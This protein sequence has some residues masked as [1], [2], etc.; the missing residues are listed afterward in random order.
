MKRAS[1]LV[2][3]LALILLVAPARAQKPDYL[4]REEVEK[5]RETQEPNLRIQLFLQFA[6]ERLR[7]F[8]KALSKSKDPDELGQLLD[9][10]IRALDDTADAVERPLERGGVDLHKTRKPVTEG[11][12]DYLARLQHVQRSFEV[13]KQDL[14]Y[15]L[16][17]AIEAT[18][19]L[20]ALGKRIPDEPIPPKFPGSVA[21]TK[22]DERPPTPGRP[23]LRRRNEKKKKP[24]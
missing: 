1:L 16:E 24:D 8:E 17:D 23:T 11:G 22:S 13:A 15:E 3:A 20:F 19:D 10:F 5:V 21:G 12:Q 4:N 9:N 6:D 14:R 7:T 18:R 2:P